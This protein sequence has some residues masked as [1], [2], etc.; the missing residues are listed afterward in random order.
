MLTG[1]LNSAPPLSSLAGESRQRKLTGD[2]AQT[3][4]VDDRG[5]YYS[6]ELKEPTLKVIKDIQAI[7]EEGRGAMELRKLVQA[8]G[9]KLTPEQ[10][11]AMAKRGDIQF[12]RTSEKSGVFSNKGQAIKVATEAATLKIPGEVSGTYE[13]APAAMALHFSSGK[14]INACKYIVCL[15]MNTIIAD[16]KHISIDMEGNNHDQSINF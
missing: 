5:D 4:G 7:H 12:A 2:P 1:S 9:A 11:K 10:E 15:D 8:F 13:I 6:P 3:H 14:T 16:Q